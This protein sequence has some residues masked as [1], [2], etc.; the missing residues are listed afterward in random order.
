MELEVNDVKFTILSYFCLKCT[1]E[2]IVIANTT[3]DPNVTFDT[4]DIIFTLYLSFALVACL[5]QTG[6]V[7]WEV[8]KVILVFSFLRMEELSLFVSNTL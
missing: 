3:E 2:T 8:S 6:N 5:H 1:Y 4:K 7:T